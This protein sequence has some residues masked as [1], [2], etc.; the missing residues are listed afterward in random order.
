MK[1][2]TYLISNETREKMRKSHLGVKHT[3]K[4]NE[5]IS[6][7]AK[8]K[9]FGKWM[10]GKKH[11]KNTKLKMSLAKK[12]KPFSGKICD[13]NGKKHKPESI[14]KMRMAKIGHEC[15]PKTRE[16]IAKG[17]RGSKCHW[18]KGGITPTYRKRRIELRKNNGGFHSIGEWEH[19][20]ALY[21]WTCPRCWKK[22]PQIK[23]TRDHI[24]PLT[25]GGNDDIENIQPLC[26]SCN[27]IKNNRFIKKYK[28]LI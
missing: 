25:K 24:K 12:G 8:Q 1:N 27:S 7:V 18:W 21:G 22:E 16:K 26:N 28:Y 4:R 10:K 3:K 14:E 23:L 13:W 9:G 11:S 6:E 15:K 17:N 5:K 2:K 19:L 20:K